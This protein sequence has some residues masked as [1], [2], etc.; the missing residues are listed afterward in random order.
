[1]LLRK[2]DWQVNKS[3]GL[4]ARKV[5]QNLVLCLLKQTQAEICSN[6]PSKSQ[7]QFLGEVNL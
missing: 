3:K 6:Y 2:Q 1:M 4:P 5:N 7:D